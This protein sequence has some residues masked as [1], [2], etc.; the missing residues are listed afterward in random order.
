MIH[1]RSGNYH[2]AAEYLLDLIDVY[3]E[4][5]EGRLRMAVN[6]NRLGSEE[7]AIRLLGA[8]LS[9]PEA[10]WVSEVAF[11]QLA[12]LH[13]RAGRLERAEEVLWQGLERFPSDGRLRTQ[14]ALVLDQRRLPKRSLA[15]IG[16][17]DREAEIRDDGPSA[18]RRYGMGPQDAYAEAREALDESA[19]SRVG[20]LARLLEGAAS[21]APAGGAL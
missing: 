14:L 20:R 10:D 1:E 2:R 5:R 16:E 7:D 9:E 8:L 21:E 18:R 15:V 17:L 6:L 11:Q 4:H 3:P 19:A 12:E 13:R